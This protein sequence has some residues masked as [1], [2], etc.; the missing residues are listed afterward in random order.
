MIVRLSKVH[1]LEIGCTMKE[2]IV[3]VILAGGSGTRLWPLS[4]KSYPKQFSKLIGDQT[5]FQQC[6]IRLSTSNLLNFTNP[7]TLTNSKYRFI[8][9]EQLQEANIDPGPILIEPEGKNTAPAIIAASLY[10][11]IDNPDAILLVAPSDHVIPNTKAFHAAIS[12]VYEDVVAGKIATLGIKPNHPE[13]AYGYLEVN[14]LISEE[15]AKLLKF[16]EKPTFE[17]AVKMVNEGNFLWNAGIFIFQAKDMLNAFEQFSPKILESVKY[18]VKN[19]K[20]DLGFFRLEPEAWSECEDISIDYA[21]ME[22]VNNLITIPFL[23]DWSDLG[24]WNAVWKEHRPD[25]NGVV[26]QNDAIAIDCKNVMLRT[27]DANQQLVGLGLEN[28]LVIAMPDAVLVMNKNS[29]QDVKK[30]VSLLKDKN[31]SQAENFPKDHRPWG[32]F[33]TLTISNRFQV[34]RIHVKPTAALSL[35]SHHHRSE[36]WIVVEGT[37]KITVNSDVKLITEGESIYIPL[38]AIH[39]MENPGKVPLI[40][41]EVQTG[42]YLGEDDIIRYE[43]IYSRK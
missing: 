31:I 40:L 25:D 22:R 3:P 7:I 11:M 6:A 13:T 17:D 8:V 21:I 38:G 26:T 29:S 39:R 33:E 15:P 18:S 35:Q 43:D 5:L 24:G 2:K 41:I 16:V 9:S 23:E 37:A 27:E 10:A 19:G 14:N 12:L 42:V 34:K 30:A 32:W 36:H 20:T 1:K 28:I 4:R